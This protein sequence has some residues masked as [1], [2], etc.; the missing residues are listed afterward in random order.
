MGVAK[1]RVLVVDDDPFTLETYRA[2]LRLTGYDAEGARTGRAA[3]ARVDAERDPFQLLLV[4]LRLPDMSGLEVLASV[5]DSSPDVPVVMMSAWANDAC[6]RAARQLG[7]AEFLE[8]PFLAAVLVDAVARTLAHTARSA[9]PPPP[10][11]AAGYAAARW[12][13]LI[14]P[15][16]RFAAD[17][18]TLVEWSRLVGRSR[19]TVKTWCHAAGV[20]AND[21]LDFARALRVVLQQQ[22]RACN[23]FDHLAIV[24]PRTLKRFLDHGGLRG[25]RVVPGVA[26]FLERQRFI[27][28]PRLTAAV[29]ARLAD[30]AR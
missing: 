23:W 9:L 29:E 17:V 15:V 6:T 14:V 25:D 3:L 21:S 20:Q 27:T 2:I 10:P 16:T 1:A 26:A 4:D 12:A 18:P 7:A 8:K 13:A 30:H 11:P 19:T 28:D 22:A 24:D 5:S